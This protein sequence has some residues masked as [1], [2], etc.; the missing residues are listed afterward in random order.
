M[1]HNK[2]KAECVLLMVDDRP[3]SANSATD[4]N[5]PSVFA[6]S[7]IAVKNPN[8]KIFYRYGN[9]KPV[10]FV[11]VRQNFWSANCFNSMT[12]AQCTIKQ[13]AKGLVVLFTIK[14]GAKFQDSG[15]A[16]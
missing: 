2:K 10:E 13:T 9:Y 3:L 6:K 15:Y 8:P 12:H 5:Y 16:A 11:P 14:T 4:L 7:K 1:K